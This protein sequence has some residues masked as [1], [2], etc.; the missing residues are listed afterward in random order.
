MGLPVKVEQQTPETILAQHLDSWEAHTSAWMAYR[1]DLTR[2]QFTLGLIA[3]SVETNYGDGSIR[4]FAKELKENPETVYL[5]REVYR[6]C[7]QFWNRFQNLSWT[8]FAAIAKTTLQELDRERMMEAAA[9]GDWSVR[10]LKRAVSVK[11]VTD[12]HAA[13]APLM[14]PQMASA[15]AHWKELKPRVERFAEANPQFGLYSNDYINDVDEEME[16]PWD[17]ARTF[18]ERKIFKGEREIEVLATS[19]KWLLKTVKALCEELVEAG[20]HEWRDQGGKT[21]DARGAVRR[22]I[23][24]VA[25]PRGDSYEY[26]QGDRMTIVVDDDD[27]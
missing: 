16:A 13:T 22:L 7:Y 12:Q 6:K 27:D 8:H 20:T 3:S 5:Y 23:V 26:Y 21:D 14:D 18:I 1:E 11:S 17:S 25:E 24:P 10:E 9:D 19:T 2:N 15:I 4:K